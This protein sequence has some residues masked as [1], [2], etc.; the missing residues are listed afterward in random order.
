MAEPATP[1]PILS[2]LEGGNTAAV[3]S[4][5]C[6]R[7][8]SETPHESG[9]KCLAVTSALPG[10]GK[11]TVVAGLAAA[12][13]REPGRRVLLLEADLRRPSLT[14]LLHL[15][16]CAGLSEYLNGSSSELAVRRVE[17]WVSSLAVSG[18][19]Q[20]E[21]PEALGSGPM[22]AL[23][24]AAKV[25]YDF[26]LLDAPPLLPVTDSLLLEDMVDGFLLVVRSRQTPRAAID[27]AL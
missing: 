2:C 18:I 7:P 23:L 1:V 25:L 14:S 13:S 5:A 20:L 12:L 8:A 11:S 15:R 10:E 27:E 24:R 22:D 16:P 9:L 6:S 21:R 19:A 4:S 17:P 26:V 3:R